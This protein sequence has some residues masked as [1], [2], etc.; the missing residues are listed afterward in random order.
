LYHCYGKSK[1]QYA[2]RNIT[3]FL[4]EITEVE[5]WVTICSRS[6]SCARLQHGSMK[7]IK[8]K[9]TWV[10]S[11]REMMLDRTWRARGS[12]SYTYS[13][14][15]ILCRR[16][17]CRRGE[18]SSTCADHLQTKGVG[19]TGQT[20]QMLKLTCRWHDSR[21][22]L[23]QP[24]VHVEPSCPWRPGLDSPHLATHLH[25]RCCVG[26]R[27]LLVTADREM[28]AAESEPRPDSLITK[29]ID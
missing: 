25:P 2:P 20:S 14:F 12:L 6:F 7:K 4:V 16:P 19:A 10:T 26:E 5:S 29:L 13:H 22:I 23:I 1:W 15:P 24:A 28:S 8:G 27:H 18:R 3:T 9:H 21:V 17:A 11:T